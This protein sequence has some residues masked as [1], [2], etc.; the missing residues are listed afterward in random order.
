MKHIRPT[1]S[2]F[3]SLATIEFGDVRI[4][5]DTLEI[6]V[7]ESDILENAYNTLKQE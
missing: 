4:T 5:A 1:Y 2:E 6:T 3:K 7:Y